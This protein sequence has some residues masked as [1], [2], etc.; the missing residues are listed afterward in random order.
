MSVSRWIECTADRQVIEWR[1]IAPDSSVAF[2][3][4][5]VAAGDDETL[6]YAV[7]FATRIRRKRVS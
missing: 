2:S 6:R 3:D 1:G 4:A 7:A 5:R